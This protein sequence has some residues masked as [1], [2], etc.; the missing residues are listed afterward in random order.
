MKREL[1]GVDGSHD[2]YHI[3]R[4]TNLAL[5]LAREENIEDL[6]LVQLAALLHDVGDWKYTNRYLLFKAYIDTLTK[7]YIN[8]SDVVGPEKVRKFLESRGYPKI[9]KLLSII[10]GVSFRKELGG[11]TNVS[12]E[13]AVVQDADR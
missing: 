12:P 11:L 8:I 4:V 2:W 7:S 9:D 1:Q 5:T 10:D 3:E 13:L 6:E